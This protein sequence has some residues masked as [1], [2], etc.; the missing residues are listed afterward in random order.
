MKPG[1][2]NYQTEQNKNQRSSK[3]S[4]IDSISNR[5]RDIAI[6]LRPALLVHLEFEIRHCPDINNNLHR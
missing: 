3:S 1:V 5:L 6:L 2:D 4:I